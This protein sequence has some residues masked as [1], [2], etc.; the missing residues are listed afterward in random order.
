MEGFT[1]AETQH[2]FVPGGNRDSDLKDGVNEV[3]G[4]GQAKKEII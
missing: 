4:L 2:L 3:F 1:W